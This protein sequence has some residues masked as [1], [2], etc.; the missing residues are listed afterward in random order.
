MYKGI[1]MN[2][3]KVSELTLLKITEL[4]EPNGNRDKFY[5]E[6]YIKQEAGQKLQIIRERNIYLSSF[7][8][9]C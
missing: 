8:L 6:K 1:T 2:V 5:G 4:S 9:D 7:I 3:I